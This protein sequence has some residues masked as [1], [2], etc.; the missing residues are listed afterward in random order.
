MYQRYERARKARKGIGVA[1]VADGRCTICNIGL[2]P[3]FYQDVKKGD[4]V[5]SCENCQRILYIPDDLP[6]E[7][8]VN[9][10]KERKDPTSKDSSDAA[11]ESQPNQ[12]QEAERIQ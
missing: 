6:P 8:A 2:R 9:K 7:M 4:S 10:R 12:P 3:Q 1:E 11:A 5:L